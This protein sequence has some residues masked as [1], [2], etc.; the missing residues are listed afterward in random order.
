MDTDK[1]YTFMKEKHHLKVRVGC[2]LYFPDDLHRPCIRAG[3]DTQSQK[4]SC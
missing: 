2:S 4:S 3:Y 1:D